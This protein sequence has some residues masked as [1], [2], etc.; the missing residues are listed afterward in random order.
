MGTHPKG[1]SVIDAGIEELPL[2]EFVAQDP[3][4]VLGQAV[5]DAFEGRLPF[6]FKVLDVQKMLSIQAHPTKA[7][8]GA[9]FRRENEA[10]IPLTA[11]HRN[12]RDDNHKPEVMVAL[13]DF[14]LLHGFRPVAEIRGALQSVPEL[15]TLLP[16]FADGDIR[17]LYQVI[18][19]MPQADVDA[20]LAPMETR[21]YAASFTPDQPEHWAKLAFADYT[22]GGHYDRGIFS[23]FLLNLLHLRTG[24]GIFQAAGIPHA[25]LSGVN[26][27]LM[28]NSDNVFR[29]GLTPKHVDV[30][31]LLQHLSFEPAVPQILHGQARGEAETVYPTPAPD[32]EVSRI[33]LSAAA[34]FEH[35]PG[36]GPA[37]YIV[38]EG[39]AAAE[40][41]TFQRG[42]AFFL[43]NFSTARLHGDGVLFRAGAGRLLN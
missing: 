9:G 2:G 24:E 16:H 21:L 17:H 22:H 33:D 6:L 4:G 13:T 41:H 12:Y 19:Q 11:D 20:L 42:E 35:R 25:Y 36:Q 37:I 26:I 34:H 38:M 7:A 1:M 15:V 30:A 23:I 31:E 10:G 8:A 29:G 5:A 27:E 14:W 3:V 43:P 40:G 18:M 28:A 39:S 32:F